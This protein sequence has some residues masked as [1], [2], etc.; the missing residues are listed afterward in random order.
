MV[1]SSHSAKRHGLASRLYVIVGLGVG[2]EV[3]VGL[4]VGLEVGLSVGLE[5]VGLGVGGI[6]GLGI[7]LEVGGIWRLCNMP[8]SEVIGL[9]V[10][11]ICK[12]CNMPKSSLFVCNALVTE[13]ADDAEYDDDPAEHDGHVLVTWIKTQ[14]FCLSFENSESS[15]ASQFW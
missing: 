4:G 3:I 2:L 10:G 6:V 12:S 9:E 7:G 15:E 8:K 11:G 5:V 13:L 1:E 14:S